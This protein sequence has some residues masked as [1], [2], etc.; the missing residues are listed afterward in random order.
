MM[1]K[2]DDSIETLDT[3]LPV[4]YLHSTS[5]R[6]PAT[7]SKVRKPRKQKTTSIA[8]PLA[9]DVNRNIIR[10]SDA[11]SQTQYVCVGCNH[12]MIVK[13]GI[14]NAHHFAHKTKKRCDPD[15]ALHETAK[16]HIIKQFRDACESG[17][18]YNMDVPCSECKQ[19]KVTCDVTMYNSN[20]NPEVSV[21]DGTRSD[22]A[23]FKNDDHTPYTIVEVVVTHDLEASTRDA[24]VKSG[25]PVILV[26]PS[27]SNLDE[28][29]YSLNITCTLCAQRAKDIMSL[30]KVIKS[31][32][33]TH[34]MKDTPHLANITADQYGRILSQKLKN[35]VNRCA[36]LLFKCG[37]SQ[38][39]SRPTLF[40]YETS[41][42]KI[43]ADLD[44]TKSMP[45]WESEGIPALYAY[46]NNKTISKQECRPDCRECVLET[47]SNWLS[48][49]GIET[50]RHFHN[51]CH[52]WHEC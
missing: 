8:Y 3:F 17:T 34:S 38:Q 16:T 44:S 51:M 43:Y 23:I 20:I 4:D 19:Q 46:K 26:R 28:P 21:V 2:T 33:N 15:M 22:L 30:I 10:I 18:S 50:R 40:M 1:E 49:M 29:S 25:I 41:F 37:F 32:S 45:I 6:I 24:Y 27:W 14:R 47:V 11:V 39:S 12:P 13:R 35:I 5:A 31:T 52:H 36:Y 9:Y 42:W 7:S 48:Q